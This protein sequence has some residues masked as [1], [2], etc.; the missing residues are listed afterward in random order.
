MARFRLELGPVP[1]H[2]QVYLDL[3]GALDNGE[4]AVGE[5]IPPLQSGVQ[6][7][8]QAAHLVGIGW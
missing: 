7:V 5:R 1:L 6:Q 3:K 4:W 2:H 8:K